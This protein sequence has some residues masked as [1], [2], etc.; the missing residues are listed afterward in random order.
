MNSNPS[1]IDERSAFMIELDK[2]NLQIR[3]L[4]LQLQSQEEE[5]RKLK[6]LN[7]ETSLK[8]IRHFKN[9]RKSIPRLIAMDDSIP[10]TAESQSNSVQGIFEFIDFF[11]I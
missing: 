11:R 5:T 4:Q 3:E 6:Q 1:A 2:A 8:L 9:E 7:Q 10:L